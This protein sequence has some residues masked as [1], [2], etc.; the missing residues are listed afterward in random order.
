[1][2]G[3]TQLTVE[4]FYS[5]LLVLTALVM[6]IGIGGTIIPVLPGLWLIWAAG[7][8][9]GLMAG[10]GTF[11]PWL[12]ALMTLLAI[13]GTIITFVMGQQGAAKA[14]ASRWSSLGGLVG[15][16]I[17][18]FVIPVVGF[19]VGGLLGIFLV[20]WYR[21]KDNQA[22]WLTTKGAIIGLGKGALVE[23]LIAFIMV[24]CWVGWVWLDG[25]W[26]A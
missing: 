7:L 8:V 21:L 18:F 1:M 13:G 16:V 6:A 19:I 11:G 14:G 15:G 5:L 23:I 4:F 9:Y 22:A 10:F 3:I 26:T 25:P 12:F 17:G 2:E 24:G 20:E